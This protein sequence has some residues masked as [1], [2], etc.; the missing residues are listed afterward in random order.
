MALWI[1]QCC[2]TLIGEI[3]FSHTNLINNMIAAAATVLVSSA[4]VIASLD[5]NVIFYVDMHPRKIIVLC[6]IMMILPLLVSIICYG[7]LS[8]RSAVG[9]MFEDKAIKY[10]DYGDYMAFVFCLA[11]PAIRKNTRRLCLLLFIL[12][13]LYVLGSKAAFVGVLMSSF[14][15]YILHLTKEKCF[16]RIVI[17]FFLLFIVACCLSTSK[18]VLY[19]WV[20]KE[21][22]WGLN[23]IYEGTKERSFYTR[24]RLENY[25]SK[26]R[27][28]RII[29]GD[30]KH[31]ITQGQGVGTY[32]HSVI[33]Y[34]D[35]Y[36]VVYF[37]SL[38]LLY[39]AIYCQTLLRFFKS[40]NHLYTSSILLL[41]Y[42][43]ILSIFV[44]SS[45]ANYAYLPLALAVTILSYVKAQNV[46]N[47]SL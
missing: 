30:Y 28:H 37:I 12:F 6:I 20:P 45:H 10:Q 26:T 39:I 11:L 9:V 21:Y 8:L 5:K 32:T 7:S 17:I 4:I 31:E 36:G 14:I 27:R 3:V 22:H 18:D 23:L 24:E 13:S 33:D 34:L 19:S 25:N 1:Y 40:D 46:K 47:S 29:L 2:L 35:Q 15:V 16:T 42:W 44:R 38:C 41:T 43:G